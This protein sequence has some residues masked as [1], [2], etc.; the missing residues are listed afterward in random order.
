MNEEH[1]TPDQGCPL[2]GGQV[3]RWPSHFRPWLDIWW[4]HECHKFTSC[5]CEA[6][7]ILEALAEG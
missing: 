2:C 5:P 3:R 7:E 6:C 4:C 1:Y